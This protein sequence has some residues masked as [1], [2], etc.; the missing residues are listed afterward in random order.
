MGLGNRRP[1]RLS[2]ERLE[3]RDA[4]AVVPTGPEFRVNANTSVA[5]A[6]PAVALAANGDFVVTWQADAVDGN[7]LAVMARKYAKAGT[8]L[9]GEFQVNTY[10]TGSQQNPAV[11]AD[12]AG[13]F[14]IV[15]GS[16]SVQDGSRE[17]VYMRRYDAAGAAISGE[18]LVNQFTLHL[19]GN[20]AI[21][22]DGTGD[23]VIAWESN[24][25][26]GD[27]YAIYA[28]KY[29]A[30]GT[31]LTSEFAVN[32][33]TLG[34]QQ[35][36]AVSIDTAGDFVVAWQSP[37]AN[38]YGVFA[39]RYNAAGAAQGTEFA[40]NVQTIDDQT[41]PAVANDSAGNFTV[42][43]QSRVQDSGTS[44]VYARRFNAVGTALSTDIRVN[45]FVAGDQTAPA[46]ASTAE[47]E[48]TIVWTSFGQDGD[49]GG[50]Y[51]QRIN[52]AGQFIDSETRVHTTLTGNQS[53]AAVANDAV[54]DAT[55]VWSATGSP[56]SGILAQRYAPPPAPVATLTVDDG[57]GQRSSIRYLT[58]TFNT[59]VNIAAGGVILTG[60]AGNV[61]LAFD[62]ASSTGTQT[63]VRM[64]L[65]GT[66][67]TPIG[68]VN[69]YY[70]LTLVSSL[71]TNL[72]GVNYDG[73]DDGIP[74]PNGT[75]TFHRWF[76]DVDGDGDV[77]AAD[78]I[79]FRLQIGSDSSQPGFKYWFDANNDGSI[80]G[81]DLSIFR[82]VFA[83]N[84]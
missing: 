77:D 35:N 67:V 59:L 37:D 70:T 78:F 42:A 27:G 13:N 7:G 48:L 56:L 73:N 43:W 36:A 64:A 51:G 10:A 84:I 3:G 9:T 45:T 47:G 38:G 31:P 81:Y 14:V 21:A 40:V 72:N 2:C 16:A 79:V 8:P 80:S 19:Q 22:M 61:T 50:I 5:V 44:G 66:G 15:W 29:N 54:G 30:A 41:N 58:L 63:I 26:D 82:L 71:I 62:Y 6:A 46:I 49:A 76:G 12:S 57:S 20:P 25:Q 74:G 18:I 4:P 24:Y 23:F 83:T 17:G 65:S 69:G 39:R 11:A 75:M 60:P 52:A 32:Q 68:L 28:R 1:P 34:D 53:Q 33:T 55:V